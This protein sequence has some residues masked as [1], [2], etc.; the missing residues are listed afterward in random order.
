M[1]IAQVVTGG[2]GNGTFSTTIPLVLLRGLSMPVQS[3]VTSICANKPE[4]LTPTLAGRVL[5]PSIT[6]QTG[7][8]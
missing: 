8:N 6:S 2:L 7:C 3:T 4:M 5:T 1:A